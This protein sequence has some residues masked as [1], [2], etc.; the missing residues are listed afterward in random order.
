M[1]KDEE[2]LQKHAAIVKKRQESLPPII[3]DGVV[4]RQILGGK[5]LRPILY[6]KMR[7][8][9]GVITRSNDTLKHYF[10]YPTDPVNGIPEGENYERIVATMEYVISEMLGEYLS[11]LQTIHH[12]MGEHIELSKKYL[13]AYETNI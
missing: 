6:D 9:M 4:F 3:L 12:R 11:E 8:A 2:T 7:K 13:Q 1:Q 5:M 10:L